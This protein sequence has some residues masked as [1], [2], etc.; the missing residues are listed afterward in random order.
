MIIKIRKAIVITTMCNDIS[1][2]MSEQASMS[3]LASNEQ[4]GTS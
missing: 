3:K 4:K 1:K 2:R